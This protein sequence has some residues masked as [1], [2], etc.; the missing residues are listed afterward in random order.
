M[1]G[2]IAGPIAGALING[3]SQLLW[4]S[5][6]QPAAASATNYVPLVA[7][8]STTTSA[9]PSTTA[10]ATTGVLGVIQYSVK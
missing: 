4:S 3:I 5:A 7:A 10:S 8:P 9:P 6:P 2:S 1:V